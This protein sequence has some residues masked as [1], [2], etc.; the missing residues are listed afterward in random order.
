M[1]ANETVLNIIMLMILITNRVIHM[2][3]RVGRGG[4]RRVSDSLI[5][6]ALESKAMVSEMCT[7]TR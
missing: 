6:D 1:K 3:T 2:E 4:R 5:Q 7:A